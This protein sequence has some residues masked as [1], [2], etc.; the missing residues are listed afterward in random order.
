MS[1]S[2]P[3]VITLSDGGRVALWRRGEASRIPG[4]LFRP[5]AIGSY[6][7]R[8]GGSA[9]GEPSGRSRLRAALKIGARI[10]HVLKR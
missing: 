1:R 10:A 3:F 5:C 4:A 2:L 8:T 9:R 6:T 7:L